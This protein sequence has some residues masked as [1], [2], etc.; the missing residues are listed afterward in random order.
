[1]PP[2]P[3]HFLFSPKSRTL[4]IAKIAQMTDEESYECFKAIRFSE[5]NGE[6]FCP[7]CGSFGVNEYRCRK[8]FKCKGCF[9]QFSV[10]SGTLLH[11]RKLSFR[12]ILLA[13]AFFTSPAKGLAA[14][15]L[16]A[17]VEFSYK[18]AW[19]LAHK[20]REAMDRNDDPTPL[21][22][23]VEIDGAEFGGYVRPKNVKKDRKDRRRIL[24]R[25]SDT[26][27]IVVTARERG[28][29]ARSTVV[30]H[31]ADGIA[32]IEANVSHTASLHADQAAGWNIL[33]FSYDSF[34][35]INHK[36]A[37]WTPESNTNTVENHFSMLRRAERAIYHHISSRHLSAY[38]REM[39]WR[40]NKRKVSKQEKFDAL[41]RTV[42]SRGRSEM[43]GL[44][45]RREEDL[46][47]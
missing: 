4:S 41:A 28:G 29:R 23:T 42:T 32:F 25:N 26:K 43:K 18:A 22:G 36:V 8:V 40:Q 39:D 3:Q 1:M 13:I 33:A 11:G 14:T 45:K 37:Y 10:T 20:L 6:P 30:K 9:K 17:Y 16:S 15:D 47:A 44:W 5:T 31:E 27:Q 35:R 7:T 34:H 12:K 38:A 2:R 19:V 46:A 24:W 21:K